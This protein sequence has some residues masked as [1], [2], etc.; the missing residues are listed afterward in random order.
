MPLEPISVSAKWHPNP[1]NS[2]EHKC[3]RQ[4]TDSRQTTLR[5]NRRSGL[6]CESDCAIRRVCMVYRQHT[7]TGCVRRCWSGRLATTTR[8]SVAPTVTEWRDSVLICCLMSTPHT[9]ANLPSLVAVCIYS[10][11]PF[12]LP[13]KV[14]NARYSVSLLLIMLSRPTPC[15]SNAAKLCI[16]KGFKMCL[17]DVFHSCWAPWTCSLNFEGVE[18]LP[19]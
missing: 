17:G 4:T 12:Q 10:S 6:C 11:T 7:R 13:H 15:R 3:D 5:R 14:Q 1:S 2:T 9:P 8:G 16:F 18:C 19:E